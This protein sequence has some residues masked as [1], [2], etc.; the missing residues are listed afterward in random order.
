MEDKLQKHE[1]VLE[2]VVVGVPDKD[3][4]EIVKAYVKIDIQSSEELKKELQDFVKL[5]LSRHEY[6]REIEF[7]KEIPKTEGGKINRKEVKKWG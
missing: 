1:N 6:P 3:R 4:G 5:E 7:V 2:A